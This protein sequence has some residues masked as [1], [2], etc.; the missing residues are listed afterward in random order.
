MPN[1]KP[2]L[3]PIQTGTPEKLHTQALQTPKSAAYASQ[4]S[5]GY[6][7]SPSEFIKTEYPA[8]KSAPLQL[9]SSIHEGSARSPSDYVK[10]E[11]PDLK[12]PVEVPLA[13]K[14]FLD[15][16]SRKFE[17]AGPSF[18]PTS[19]P[20]SAMSGSFM[21]SDSPDSVNLRSPTVSLPPATPASAAPYRRGY[22]PCRLRTQHSSILS[23]GVDSPRSATPRSATILRSPFSPDWKL[24]YYE[25]PHS[26]TGKPV[27]VREIVTRTVTYK[28]T[29]LDAP[30]KGKR[31]KCHEAK[32]VE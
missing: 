18:S 31:R 20:A 25:A 9:S 6:M 12:T 30:P 8:L 32:E 15:N 5:S 11:E 7:P 29:Q 14:A 10:H 16:L 13:Y 3:P 22:A 28:R 4:L 23:P 21:F 1:A 2:I 19:Q 24:R 26:A 17:K 27:S